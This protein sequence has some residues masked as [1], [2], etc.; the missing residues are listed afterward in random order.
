M[1]FRDVSRVLRELSFFLDK[2]VPQVKFVDRTFNCKKDHALPIL[3]HILEHDNKITN[4]HFEIS[5]DLLDEEQMEVL[6]QMRP[7]HR[8]R[9]LTL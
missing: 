7:R 5:A 1:D 9:R 3:Q 6:R 2:K 8:L 4:F